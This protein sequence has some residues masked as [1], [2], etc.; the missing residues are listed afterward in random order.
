MTFVLHGPTALISTKSTVIID[1]FSGT[2][3]E[4]YELT[5]SYHE[6]CFKIHEQATK[7]LTCVAA[8]DIEHTG[9]TQ[10]LA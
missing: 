5:F 1:L 2:F 10:M 3:D 9:N 7:N 4:Y 6:Y 8:L